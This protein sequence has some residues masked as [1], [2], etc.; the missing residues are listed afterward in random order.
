MSAKM[1]KQIPTIPFFLSYPFIDP[2]SSHYTLLKKLFFILT[3]RRL[4]L[5]I[6]NYKWRQVT[7]GQRVLPDFLIIGEPK[8]GTTSLFHYISQSPSVISPFA[9]ETHYF[10]TIFHLNNPFHFPNCNNPKLLLRYKKQYASFFPK[11]KE[12]KTEEK[13]QRFVTGE[14]SPALLRHGGAHTLMQ[15]ILPGHTKFIVIFRNPATRSRS[16][17]YFINRGKKKIRTFDEVVKE[18]DINEERKK[19]DGIKN[20]Y[21]R[22][23]VRDA[24]VLNQSIEDDGPR[25]L[26]LPN[27]ADLLLNWYKTFPDKNKLLILSFEEMIQAPQ[28]TINVVADFLEIPQYKLIDFKNIKPSINYDSSKNPPMTKETMVK[29]SELFKP[30]NQQLYDITSKNFDWEYSA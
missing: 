25:I 23:A 20:L 1:P 10:D 2:L 9:K 4:F 15:E 28:H 6:L 16:L 22:L 13:M 7:A 17:Y 30:Y 11:E 12:M 14:A 29:L 26:Y 19:Y 8:C 5:N 27:Y 21:S 3:S 18:V 24:K